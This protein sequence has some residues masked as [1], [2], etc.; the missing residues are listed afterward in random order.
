MGV[1]RLGRL[2]CAYGSKRLFDEESRILVVSTLLAAEKVNTMESGKSAFS[3][4]EGEYVES[5]ADEDDVDT[6]DIL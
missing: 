2:D 4:K 3:D 6:G 1:V 5:V